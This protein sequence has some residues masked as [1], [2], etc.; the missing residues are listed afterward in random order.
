MTAKVPMSETGTATTSEQRRQR[1]IGCEDDFAHESQ[2]AALQQIE[3][4][5]IAKATAVYGSD[6]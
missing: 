1:F 6:C 4:T 5:T 3:A 2:D